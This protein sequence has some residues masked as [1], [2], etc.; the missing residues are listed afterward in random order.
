MNIS[1][2]ITLIAFLFVAVCLLTGR[3]PGSIAC[4]TAVLVLWF[5]H[6]ITEKEVFANF[7]SSSIVVMVCMMIVTAALMKTDIMPS[8]ANLVRRAKGGGIAILLVVTMIVPYILCQFV[9][10][11]TSMIIVI[12]LAMALAAE[13]GVSPTVMVLPA[14]VGA[15]AGLLS[16]PIGG[17]AAMYLLKNQLMA[18]V[19]VAEELGF[20]DLFLV[21]LPGTIAIFLFVLLYGWKLLPQRGLGKS[22]M[23]DSGRKLEKS[24]L[25]RWKQNLIY[26]I[27]IATMVL[28]SICGKIGL[29]NTQVSLAAAIIVMLL[30]LVEEREAYASVNWPLIFMMSFML[31]VST[32]LGNSGAGEM[33]A[34]L[35]SPVY[36]S[37]NMIVAVV[38]TFIFCAVATQFMDN[39]TLV[40]ILTPICALACM[41]NG[42]SALPV[43]VAIDAS[44][45]ISF[46]TPLAS[47]SSLLAYQLGGYSM[48]EMLKFNLPLIMIS[49]VVSCI[50]IPIYISIAH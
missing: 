36:G 25:P 5:T 4:G 37:G 12:P 41:Q 49:T 28:L 38:V 1:L 24:S 48:K 14:S 34:N 11:V 15:Q 33:L 19:G 10:G 35:L 29:T 23:L 46:S 44:C 6:V 2:L 16:L 47:P 39:M 43:V 8:I 42:M 17:G 50:W 45:L 7:V 9:G 30:R 32:A 18:S 31:A 27:F 26:G 3:I 22:S 20:W 40:N 21:R 13:A